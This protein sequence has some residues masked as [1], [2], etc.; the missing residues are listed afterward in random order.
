MAT[1]E[2]TVTTKDVLNAIGAFNKRTGLHA[3]LPELAN[4]LGVPV[5][6]IRE[7]VNVL[8]ENGNVRYSE[9]SGQV[10]VKKR[11]YPPNRT[12]K[13]C[14]STMPSK[15]PERA[16]EATEVLT[17]G[18]ELAEQGPE[19]AP[20]PQIIGGVAADGEGQAEGAEGQESSQVARTVRSFQGMRLEDDA[21]RERQAKM[22]EVE[23]MRILQQR[24][25]ALRTANI[26]PILIDEI[27]DDETF[28]RVV[29][30][31]IREGVA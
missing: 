14:P 3:T 1:A 27:H 15:A 26:I 29:R 4:T 28:G 10:Y 7:A 8:V 12:R 25:V 9:A 20:E 21:E 19:Q 2:Q 11:P 30:R 24:A 18:V 23:R 13:A 22:A 17:Q 31:L 16:Q 5:A 6:T